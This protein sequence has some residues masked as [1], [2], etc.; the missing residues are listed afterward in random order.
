MQPVAFGL[1]A[2]IEYIE[3]TKSTPRSGSRDEIWLKYELYQFLKGKP[4]QQLKRTNQ[5]T[6]ITEFKNLL[7]RNTSANALLAHWKFRRLD[8][9]EEFVNMVQAMVLPFVPP[10][11]DE[12]PEEQDGFRVNDAKQCATHLTQT[13]TYE[14]LSPFRTNEPLGEQVLR[15]ISLFF[16]WEFDR[17]L[18]YS[19]AGL[20][21]PG[22]QMLAN[23]D[24]L[25]DEFVELTR[26]HTSPEVFMNLCL[27]AG[28]AG[29]VTHYFN[30]A[31]TAY[32]VAY[33]DACESF[34]KRV[35]KAGIKA[36]SKENP[37]DVAIYIASFWR[38]TWRTSLANFLN[39][40]TT[41]EDLDGHFH[42]D[43]P[44]FFPEYQFPTTP[45]TPP[46]PPAPPMLEDAD[47]QPLAYAS[48]EETLEVVA[49]QQE[50]QDLEFVDVVKSL[51]EV[52]NAPVFL[53]FSTAF[54]E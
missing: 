22:Q 13:F 18:F 1:P 19:Y 11:L 53:S 34:R 32:D 25:V 46:I 14:Q 38:P 48:P 49:Q 37:L 35:E 6:E 26:R 30:L 29:L 36:K 21:N 28:V 47:E 52:L 2:S 40:R 15:A 44:W 27:F 24:A 16:R 4:M 54:D 23:A 7:I 33:S 43:G 31:N 39:N 10:R 42:F 9:Y 41:D 45:V 5:S 8:K 12:P 3:R 51:D 17:I 20:I 50:D